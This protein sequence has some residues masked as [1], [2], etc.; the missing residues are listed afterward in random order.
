VAADW[1]CC[2]PRSAGEPAANCSLAKS[3]ASLSFLLG[4]LGIFTRI[5]EEHVGLASSINRYENDGSP[6]VETIR[7]AEREEQLQSLDEA[8][9]GRQSSA[10]REKRECPANHG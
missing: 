7:E 8:T 9:Q 4:R 10:T 3:F 1:L 2:D 5:L 6:E